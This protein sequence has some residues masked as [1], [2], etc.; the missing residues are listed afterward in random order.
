MSRSPLPQEEEVE[1]EGQEAVERE[2]EREEA[3][4]QRHL[5]EESHREEL[6][7]LRSHY[8]RLASD[9]EERH[10]TQLL[11]LEQRLQLLGTEHRLLGGGLLELLRSLGGWGHHG[12]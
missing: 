10:A 2:R 9:A 6:Q 5:L 1:R 4:R 3:R 8:T 7:R 12:H 11:V